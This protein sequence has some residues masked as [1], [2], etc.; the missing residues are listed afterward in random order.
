M[1]NIYKIS[2]FGE[3]PPICQ[4]F[5]NISRNLKKPSVKKTKREASKKKR[6]GEKPKGDGK[7]RQ[8][9]RLTYVDDGFFRPIC[10]WMTEFSVT[11]VL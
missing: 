4:K 9:Y 6:E 5:Y 8:S 3:M 7:F 1:V 2:K 11:L 10:M